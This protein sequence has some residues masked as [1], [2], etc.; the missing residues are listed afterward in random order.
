MMVASVFNS[1]ERTVADFKA[2]FEEIDQS[3]ELASAIEPEGSDLGIVEFV[4][5]G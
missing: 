2:L 4:W 1:Q 3:F 5:K